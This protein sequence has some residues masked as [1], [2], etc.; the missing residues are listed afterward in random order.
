MKYF[1]RSLSYLGLTV[2]LFA[3]AGAHKTAKV[4]PPVPPTVERPITSPASA[5]FQSTPDAEF[6]AKKPAALPVP[7]QFVAPV[8]VQRKLKNGMSVLVV[9]NHQVPIVAIEVLIKTGHDGEPINKTGLSDLVAAMLS[10]GTAKRTSEEFSV[11]VEDLAGLLV[12][13]SAQNGT[14][15]HLNCLRETMAD[16][17]DLLADAVIHPA[18]RTPDF[19]RVR[20]VHLARLAQKKGSPSLIADD[21]MNRL[22][23]GEKHPWG[24][25]SGGTPETVKSITPSDLISFHKAYYR[26][27]NAV[28]SVSGDTSVDE[29]V[30]LLDRRFG[31]W[32]RGPVRTPKLPAF[33]ELKTRTVTV[34]DKPGAS[35]SQIWVGGRLFAAN[36]PDATAIRVANYVLGGLFSSRL[37]LNLRED[38]GYSYGVSSRVALTRTTGTLVASGGIIAKNTPE[39]LVEYEKELERFTTG[40]FTDE[41]L[42]QAKA[43]DI[44]RLP[45]RLE[46]NDAVATALNGLILDGLPLDYYAT[47]P[48][49]VEKLTKADVARAAAKYVKP[50][51]WP[52]VVVGPRAENEEKL[53]QLGLGH[54]E[55]RSLDD[56]TDKR[57][58]R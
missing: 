24:Q 30:K 26:P 47:L 11:A 22:L 45:S 15:I 6:R 23:F 5:D 37:N 10:E 20:G 46:T 34:V 36:H 48:G 9:E 51:Q 38:K 2:G 29:V 16:A 8:P 43:A 18:F 42:M 57:A 35:Q 17:T 31:S 44:R 12:A 32:K 27:N 39:A 49:D 52:V 54:I 55:V 21:E 13:S 56:S 58:A 53:R 25:R 19:E 33:P 41:E 40:D 7:P 3:C 14:R 28:I 4:E 50:Q 1:L